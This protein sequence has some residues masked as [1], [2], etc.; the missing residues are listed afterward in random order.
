MQ[1]FVTRPGCDQLPG[2]SFVVDVPALR[3]GHRANATLD[4]AILITDLGCRTAH[5]AQVAVDP[6]PAVCFGR[7]S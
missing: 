2:A 1:W 5:V 3:P 7:A 6:S 4:G